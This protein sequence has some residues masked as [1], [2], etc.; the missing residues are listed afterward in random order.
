MFEGID[1]VACTIAGR[2]FRF[3]VD[4]ERDPI[5]RHHRTG[6][7][8]EGR[9]LSL[10]KRVMPLGGTYVDIGA[11]VGNHSLY[12]AAFLSPAKVIPFEPNVAAYK[13]LLANVAMNGFGGVFDL[14]WL[15]LGLSDKPGDGFAMEQRTRNL[16]ASRMLPGQG[17][18]RVV[19]GDDA[20]A[21]ESPDFIKIDVESM[22]L[23]VLTGLEATVKRCGPWMLIEVDKHNDEGFHGWRQ[24]ADYV[25]ETEVQRYETSTNYLVRPA[26][27]KGA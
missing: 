23:Q 24:R 3:A 1:V 9:E 6:L 15:G 10:I 21:A 17:D 16:G 25:V 18:L 11:N 14:S 27:R 8:Y 13:L 5:Q 4:M 22:E 20:L 12:V 7:L 26:S 19:A 2:P